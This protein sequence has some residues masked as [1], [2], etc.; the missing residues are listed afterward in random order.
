MYGLRS[1]KLDLW[2]V[3]IS[4]RLASNSMKPTLLLLSSGQLILE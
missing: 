4:R 2:L 3:A 1:T